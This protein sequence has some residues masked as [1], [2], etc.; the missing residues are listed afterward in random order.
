VIPRP[1]RRIATLLLSLPN[2]IRF[3]L[4]YFPWAQ[5]RRLPVLVSNRVWLDRLGG[6]V[7]ITGDI[8]TAMVRIGFGQV[9]IF[10]RERS[11]SVWSVEGEVEFQG[12]ALL[13][14]GTRIAIDPTGRVVFGPGFY[15]TAESSIECRKAVTFGAEVLISWDVLI[16]DSDWHSVVDDSGERLNP[17]REIEIGNHVWIGSRSTILK[18]ARIADNSVVGAGSVVTD[19]FTAPNSLVAGIPAREIRRGIRWSPDLL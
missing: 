15:V 19:E 1:I 10:D 8:Q 5:A 18:G 2:T 17:D 4:T 12:P 7:K 16:M 13:G 11:R 14:H 3:N 9:R 6:S